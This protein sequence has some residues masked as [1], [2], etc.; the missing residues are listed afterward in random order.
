[1]SADD[2][3]SFITLLSRIAVTTSFRGSDSFLAAEG[4]SMYVMKH[5][6]K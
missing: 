6:T 5:A 1:M 4:S 3:L 2:S